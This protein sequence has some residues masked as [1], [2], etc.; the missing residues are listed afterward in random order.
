MNQPIAQL[1][2]LACHANA[3]LRGQRT[4]GFFP[5][6]STCRHCTEVSFFDSRNQGSEDTLIAAT[7]DDWFD[8][9]ARDGAR[10]VRVVLQRRNAGP[11][12]DRMTAVFVGGGSQWALAVRRA[13]STD[14]WLSRWEFQGR[15]GFG[16]WRA[17][18]HLVA[19]SPG[20]PKSQQ[21]PAPSFES[22]LQDILEFAQ[23]HEC[24][25]FA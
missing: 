23:A 1:V 7:P 14:S 4:P 17:S 6:N 16:T 21:D 19:T 10:G 24:D 2:A 3:A 8:R 11:F 13:D 25:S 15:P 5:G 20:S 18:Y 22:A 9:L 12:A